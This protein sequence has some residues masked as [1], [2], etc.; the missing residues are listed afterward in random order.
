MNMDRLRQYVREII[1]FI[2]GFGHD[3]TTT[4]EGGRVFGRCVCGKESPG[5]MV[6]SR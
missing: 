1:C 5:W 4:R 6:Y 3:M 2:T